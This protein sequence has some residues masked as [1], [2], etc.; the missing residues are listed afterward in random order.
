M[1]S[2]LLHAS[3]NVPKKKLDQ[4]L[5]WADYYLLEA[6]QRND[7]LLSPTA[8]AYVRSGTY[9]DTNFGKASLSVKHSTSGTDERWAYLT[10]D[11]Y[12]VKGTVNNARLR[13]YGANQNPAYTGTASVFAVSSTGW[14]ES[15]VTWNTK[16]KTG[17]TLS[18]SVVTSATQY[19]DWDITAY[20]QA[21]RASGKTKVSLAVKMNGAVSPGNAYDKFGARE[22]TQNGPQLVLQTY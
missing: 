22:A 19:T 2:T 20:V 4:G 10:F 17:A 13:L 9:A 8:D 14:N 7:A 18:T 15:A 6:L 16:P 11:T 1:L 5:V 3:F 12:K 21:Q